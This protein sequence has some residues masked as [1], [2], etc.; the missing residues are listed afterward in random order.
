[1]NWESFCSK[2]KWKTPYVGCSKESDISVSFSSDFNRKP[3]PSIDVKMDEKWRQLVNDNPRL[4]NGQKFRLNS[5]RTNPS[6]E[7]SPEI[8]LEVGLTDYKTAMC[9]NHCEDQ[10]SL[11]NLRTHSLEHYQDIHAC[12]ADPVAVNVVVVT[13]DDRLVLIRRAD[14]VGEA[15]GLLDVPGG[16]AEPEVRLFRK[17]IFKSVRKHRSRDLKEIRYI[18]L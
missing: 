18:F 6:S 15:K 8:L 9:T 14:W 5:V 12:F 4:F 10:V 13:S 11:S 7:S 17:L 16:H 3:C 1:M 2:C